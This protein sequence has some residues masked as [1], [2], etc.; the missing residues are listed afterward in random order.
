MNPLFKIFFL[1][2]VA[3][4]ISG[5]SSFGKGVVE[6]VMEK[7]QA[8]DTRLCEVWGKSFNGIMPFLNLQKGK[9]KVLMVHGVGDHLPGYSTQFVEKLAKELD[10]PV[11]SAQYKNITLTDPFDT[12]KNLG[13][14]RINRLLSRDRTKELMFY[15]L[16]WSVITAKQKEVLAYDNSGEYSFRRAEINDLMKKFSND[17]GPDPI[18][19]LGDSREE[20]LISFTQSFCWM[21]KSNWEN[22]PNDEAQACSFNDNSLT[23]NIDNDQYAFISHSLG[24]RITIDGMQR[25]ASLM[26]TRNS[27][28]KD[29]SIE[30]RE[31]V[32]A[33]KRKE[34][35]IYMMSNQLP[36]LQL[37]RKLPEVNNQKASY[38][39]PQGDKY[40]QRMLSKTSIIAF[41]DPNDLLS[42]AVPRGFVEKYLDSRLCI[43]VTNININVATIFDAFGLG[44]LANPINAHIGYDTD[45]RVI[46]LIAKGIGNDKTSNIV[47]ERCRW[48]DTID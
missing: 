32:E 13:N 2:V 37:G 46:A 22:L 34:I 44:K 47:N 40:D 23:T 48:I 16:T 35:P 36:M 41:S 39:R 43:D 27:Q 24:S 17:T 7:Q 18:I 33:L 19:Y 12:T 1:S 14:L 30:S 4:Q 3:A 29:D 31:L 15:E 8:V 26:D 25:I 20:I 38:C 11:M 42:Y 28:Y 10:L 6:A 5:C 45:D 9:M 21:T